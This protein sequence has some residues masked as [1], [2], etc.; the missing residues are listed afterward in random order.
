M[1]SPEFAN[2]F[3]TCRMLGSGDRKTTD[4]FVVG[5][6]P[7]RQGANLGFHRQ[8]GS[9]DLHALRRFNSD[10]HSAAVDR[11]NFDDDVVAEHNLLSI[12]A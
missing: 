2:Y 12:A 11:K 6:F 7:A 9:A 4:Y 10:A 3:A 1:F 8:L 5:G